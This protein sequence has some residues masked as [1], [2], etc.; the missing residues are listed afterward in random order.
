VI[1]SEYRRAEV[2]R[3]ATV[4]RDYGLSVIPVRCDGSKAPAS[5][6]LPQVCSVR[7]HKQSGTWEPFTQRLATDSELAT[8][9]SRPYEVAI[10]L[11]AGRVSG[12]LEI[13]DFDDGSLLDPWWD[14]VRPI[15]DR[16]PIVSTP[17]NGWHVFYRC[18]EIGGNCKIAMDRSRDKETLIE[19]RGEAGYVVGQY[20]PGSAHAT[21]GLYIHAYGPSLT[22]V[23][24]IT[25]A[26]RRE[27]WAAARTFDKAG[28]AKEIL[29]KQ[30]AQAGPAMAGDVH[31][32][33]V[34]YCERLTWDSLLTRHGWHSKDGI[35]WT[36][37]GKS[38]GTSARLVTAKDGTEV[39]TVFS[40]NAGPLSPTAGS[41]KSWSLWW[42]LV[43]LEFNGDGKA[44]FSAAKHE[45]AA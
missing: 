33:I 8:W 39:L 21:G 9:F 3:A 35:T 29:R 44:A 28:T 2:H 5:D 6:L 32:V 19:T 37:S 31:P 16:L 36:R 18:S 15:A 43:A 24:T 10:G 38:H 1:S 22:A 25:P 41:H 45:V 27:L 12:G 42:A 7:T 17:S 4:Y 20:S 14:L 11:V 23:P 34:R 13:L 26:E 30:R 40:G